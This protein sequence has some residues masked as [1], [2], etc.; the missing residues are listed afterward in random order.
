MSLWYGFFSNRYKQKNPSQIVK[1]FSKE[2]GDILSHRD[3][4]TIC[5]NGLNYSVR[6]GKR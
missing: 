6:N 4:S 5:A 2:G 3:G 1:G